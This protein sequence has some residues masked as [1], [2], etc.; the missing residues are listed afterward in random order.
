MATTAEAK[1]IRT[2][3]TPTKH[4]KKKRAAQADPPR[5]E[6]G[7][8][9]RGA[10]RR[11][12]ATD[13]I[14]EHILTGA[15]GFRSGD[16]LSEN[17]LADQLK[18]TR[19]PIRQALSQLAAEGLLTIIPRVGT[20]VRVVRPEEARA[21]MAMRFA[22]ETLIVGELARTRPDLS[23]LRTIQG[24]M[25]RIAKNATREPGATMKFVKAD[26][27]FHAKMAELANGYDT[28]AGTLKDLTSQFLLY[29]Y[30]AFQQSD[31]PAVMRSVLDE[32]KVI[33]KA[34]DEGD[35]E[36]ATRSLHRHIRTAVDRLAPFASLYLE[37]LPSYFNMQT[38][39]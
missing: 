22:I 31:W 19:T 3:G 38:E 37:K 27:D 11:D 39:N 17:Q 13:K 20:Q 10:L 32:H 15:P 12:E 7:N 1:K 29:A 5:R 36:G 21:M 4:Q 16:I 35:Q 34:L 2:S 23:P 6:D 28:A 26:M 18:L 24:E 30:R 9:P 33:L 25:E 14:R 8:R